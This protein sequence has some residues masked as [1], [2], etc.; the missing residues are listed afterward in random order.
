MHDAVFN[1]F[2]PYTISLSLAQNCMLRAAIPA[3]VRLLLA[4]DI[5]TPERQHFTLLY[6]LNQ[7]SEATCG[8]KISPNGIELKNTQHMRTC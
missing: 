6:E 7:L 1:Q 5:L 4:P 3:R 8:G 2:L